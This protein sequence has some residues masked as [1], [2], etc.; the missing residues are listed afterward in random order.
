MTGQKPTHERESDIEAY[1]VARCKAAGIHRD[2][3][4][5]PGKRSVPDDILTFNGRIVFLELKATGK[6]PTAAQYRDHARRRAVGAEV[7]WTDSK[8]G[9][10]LVV[11]TMTSG[12]SYRVRATETGK[13]AV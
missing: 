11:W 10:N 2:K 7:C 8:R 13:V 9:V 5:S 12:L 4:S 3:F 1:L 6:T